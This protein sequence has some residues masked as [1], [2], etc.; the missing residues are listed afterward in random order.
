MKIA[1]FSLDRHQGVLPAG[2]TLEIPEKLECVVLFEAHPSDPL[3]QLRVVGFKVGG[4]AFRL[5]AETDDH[6]TDAEA[7]KDFW[8]AAVLIGMEHGAEIRAALKE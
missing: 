1:R 7:F 5:E 2:V 6:P 3:N 8:L 4:L